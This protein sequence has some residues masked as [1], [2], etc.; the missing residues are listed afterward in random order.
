MQ[1]QYFSDPS[2]DTEAYRELE[3]LWYDGLCLK[4]KKRNDFFCHEKSNN[5]LEG[6]NFTETFLYGPLFVIS[7][8][9]LP[10]IIY[11]T[12]V[13]IRFYGVKN[14]LDGVLK[15]PAYLILP[16][17]TCLSFYEK[18]NSDQIETDGNTNFSNSQEEDIDREKAPKEQGNSDLYQDHEKSQ[19]D[20]NVHSSDASFQLKGMSVKQA[21]ENQSNTILYQDQKSTDD[22]VVHSSE[23]KNENP[24]EMHVLD[25]TFSNILSDNLEIDSEH[26]NAV[27]NICEL[28][29]DQ[30]PSNTKAENQTVSM[31]AWS[32]SNTASSSDEEENKTNTPRAMEMTFS[33][34]QSNILYAYYLCL[35]TL[36]LHLNYLKRVRKRKFSSPTVKSYSQSQVLS[37]SLKSYN[38][39]HE[40]RACPCRLESHFTLSFS[41]NECSHSTVNLQQHSLFPSWAEYYSLD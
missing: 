11:I 39:K 6:W 28:R 25:D 34:S 10:P 20:K 14:W 8:N 13:S 5:L 30:V 3:E 4:H 9:Y 15:N 16:V 31:K 37:L 17:T 7:L 29:E 19:E 24:D 22:Q 32:E 41:G 2:H 18:T 36:L 40:F 21:D 26:E 27:V 33:V 35:T 38:S 1:F 12:S 23:N